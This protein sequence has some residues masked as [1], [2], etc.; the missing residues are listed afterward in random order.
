MAEV[1]EAVG[2]CIQ[3]GES[4][5]NVAKMFIDLGHDVSCRINVKNF[6]NSSLKAPNIEI[7]GGQ[8]AVA[9]DIVRA[10]GSESMLGHK[11]KGCATGAYGTVSYD[12]TIGGS[13]HRIFIMYCA[14]YNFNHY[15]NTLAIGIGSTT[16]PNDKDLFQKM[17]DG[18]VSGLIQE[19]RGEYYYNSR[20]I[21]V[22]N[23]VIRVTGIM[24]TD[25][26]AEV[27]I[28]VYPIEKKHAAEKVKPHFELL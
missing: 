20:M 24:D 28:C 21:T 8:L 13:S 2:T 1:A 16:T 23:S 25:H 22:E 26:K 15:S 12:I 5:A 11:T 7:I 27:K 10:G 9:P 18:E 6:T 14:P 19:K 3:A 17:Y 4:V